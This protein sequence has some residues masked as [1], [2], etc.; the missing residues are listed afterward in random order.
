V[1][2]LVVSRDGERVAFLYTDDGALWVEARATAGGAPLWRA[3]VPAPP[4]VAVP[5][6][7]GLFALLDGFRLSLL[8]DAVV[9]QVAWN[10]P[11]RGKKVRAFVHRATLSTDGWESTAEKKPPRIEP[12]APSKPTDHEAYGLS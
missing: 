8:G 4:G 9:L 5:A 3:E 10:P 11:G 7:E 1:Q 6:E 2:D 12:G